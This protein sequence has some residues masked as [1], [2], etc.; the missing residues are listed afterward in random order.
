MTAKKPVRR[1]LFLTE[2]LGG[3][4]GNHLL[5]M[6]NL[7][8][9]TYWQAEMISQSP[10]TARIAPQIPIIFFPRRWFDRYP[11]TQIHRLL[12]IRHHIRQNLPDLVHCYFYWPIIYGRILKRLGLIKYLIENREDQGFSWNHYD[13]ALLRMT[14]S[15]PDRVICVSEAVRQ[16]V[17]EK[18]GIDPERTVVVHNGIELSPLPRP[19]NKSEAYA[20]LGITKEHC[21]VGMVANF[22]RPVKGV[23]YFLEAI[24]LI[25]RAV[26]T[27]RFLILGLGNTQELRNQAQTLGIEPYLILAGYREEVEKYY[28]IMDI[29][30]MTSLSEGLSITLL[31]S[32]GHGLPVVVTRVG[33]NPEVVIDGETGYLVPPRD[34]A[35]FA[36]RVIE[37][38]K[39]PALRVRMGQ[40]GRRRVEQCFQIHQASKKYLEIYT[41]ILEPAL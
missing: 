28:A 29:S 41:E 18:E 20:E 27:A 19:V 25:I 3:G 15:L 8:E 39:N 13:Y 9:K 36:K 10:L 34:T 4:T 22:N 35:A 32:M 7:W 17:L 24:P 11:L 33:G 26:P 23:A 40:A 30:V 14:R 38:L 1:V 16:V 21:V 31:E 6:I 12:Q 5:S 37:L 2:D